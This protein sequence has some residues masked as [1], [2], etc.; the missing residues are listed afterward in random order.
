M[1][2]EGLNRQT[3]DRENNTL[4]ERLSP[5]ISIPKIDNPNAHNTTDKSCSCGK[6]C[7]C[8]LKE[9]LPIS[10]VY[11]IG[12]IS[13]T[14]PSESIRQEFI[15]ILGRGEEE[16][17]KGLAT[18]EVMHK[19][20]T[21]ENNRYLARELCWFLTIENNKVYILV[22]RDPWD[23]DKLIQA[24]RPAP[25]T[26]DID[27]VIGRRGPLASPEMCGGEILPIV[28]VDQMYSFDREALLKAIPK[29][30]HR[31][32]EA[33][34]IKTAED[35]LNYIMRMADNTGATDQHRALNYLA[36]R[37]D[38]IYHKTQSMQDDNYSLTDIEIRQSRLSVTGKDVRVF[39]IYESRTNRGAP[40]RLS[41]K[42]DVTGKYPWVKEGLDDYPNI[43]EY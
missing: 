36:V 5:D 19:I 28:I 1:E 43:R 34:F 29:R 30:K 14:F 13:F 8:G 39:F 21:N 23:I 37:Y 4:V 16:A 20:L 31:G 7:S 17:I 40:R 6:E 9:T 26:G 2:N 32:S 12:R 22:P 42:V 18:P 15:Q 25:G 38:E 35:T 3:S 11:A 27:V 24:L 10:Y 41:V 33:Q